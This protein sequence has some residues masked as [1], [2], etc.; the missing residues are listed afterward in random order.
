MRIDRPNH[1]RLLLIRHPEVDLRLRGVC[2]GR[3]DVALSPAGHRQSFVLAKQLARLPVTRI[4]H[5]GLARTSLLARSLARL[6]G[7]TAQCDDALLERDFGSWEL[8][9]WDAIYQR[10]GDEMLKMV[11]QPD[12]FRPGGGETTRELAD[13]IWNW[14]QARQAS[15][16]TV[17]VTHGGPIAAWL[18]QHRMLPVADWLELVPACGA[19]VWTDPWHSS[20]G[21]D[22][23]AR[24]STNHVTSDGIKVSAMAQPPL[25][26]H[27]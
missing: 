6:T 4:L 17:A 12:D 20:H 23:P 8:Q 21:T 26:S 19:L 3:S 7:L 1:C 24:H 15:G 10:Q 18:G 14:Y 22:V 2:Y 25:G 9:T 16:L 5:S 27:T 11:S 13:R